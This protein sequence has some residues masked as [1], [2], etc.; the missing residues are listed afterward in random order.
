MV[1]YKLIQGAQ[2]LQRHHTEGLVMAKS[3]RLELGENIL[4][5]S[6]IIGLPTTTVT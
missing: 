2:L 4:W 3:G 5:T 6:D 1:P